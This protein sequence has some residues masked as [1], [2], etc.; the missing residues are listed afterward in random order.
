MNDM[1]NIKYIPKVAILEI[2]LLYCIIIL[3]GQNCLPV[4]CRNTIVKHTISKTKV[5]YIIQSN[6]SLSCHNNACHRG[7]VIVIKSTNHQ[8]TRNKSQQ[9]ILSYIK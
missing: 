2:K 9:I 7:T 1:K 6:H 8:T 4:I 3:L 5:K